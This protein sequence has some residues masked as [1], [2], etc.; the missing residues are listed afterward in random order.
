MCGQLEEVIHSRFIYFFLL[1]IQQQALFLVSLR[2]HL[3]PKSG[4]KSQVLEKNRTKMVTNVQLVLASLT[5]LPFIVPYKILSYSPQFSLSHVKFAGNIAD[6]LVQAGHN[7][8]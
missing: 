7:V 8:V 5:L 2:G 6:F 3:K 1:S 4:E